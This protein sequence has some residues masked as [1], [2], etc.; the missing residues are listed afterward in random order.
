MLF[1]HIY[2]YYV[3]ICLFVHIYLMHM[4]HMYSN[5]F[6][7]PSHHFPFFQRP[8]SRSFWK[9][10]NGTGSL[11]SIL[12][13][14]MVWHEM[15]IRSS[16]KMR[17]VGGMVEKL[18]NEWWSTVKF[19]QIFQALVLP[20]VILEGTVRNEDRK[21]RNIGPTMQDIVLCTSYLDDKVYA[22]ISNG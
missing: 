20:Q 2:I 15:I 21:G 9:F 12:S 6:L 10:A 14:E 4:I 19:T 5:I 8:T 3:N 22:A 13:H 16:K 17:V 11:G 7:K 18:W 1:V